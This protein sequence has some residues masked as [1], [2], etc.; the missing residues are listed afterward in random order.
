LGARLEGMLTDPVYE[1]KSL[2][3]LLDLVRGGRSAPRS[4]VLCAHPRAPP[5]PP[6][7]PPL[8]APPP[9][10]PA[11]PERLRER[12][13]ARR[14]VERGSSRPPRVVA[15]DAVRGDAARLGEGGREARR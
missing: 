4:R 2:A 6:P 13:L 11:G 14:A 7:P 15:A 8:A 9:R 12:F 10:R 1:G 3:A 5:A